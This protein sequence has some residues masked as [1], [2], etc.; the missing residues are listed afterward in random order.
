MRQSERVLLKVPIEVK[1]GGEKFFREK[2]FTLTISRYGAQIGLRHPLQSDDR[3]T[4]TNLRNN[5]SCPFRVVARVGKPL[6]EVP[7]WGVECLEPEV[8][9]W[10]ISFPENNRVEA[11]QESVE[12]LLECSRCHFREPVRLAIE[13]YR[14]LVIQ[15]ALARHC[16]KCAQTTQWKFGFG[17]VKAK[18]ARARRGSVENRRAKR[19]KTHF[20]ARIR[21]QDGREE[22]TEVEDVSKS[23]LRMISTLRM[24]EGERVRI[25]VGHSPGGNQREVEARVVW[26]EPLEDMDRVM[27]GLELDDNPGD[28]SLSSPKAN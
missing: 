13:E 9:I 18:R 16:R 12:S 8:D 11:V 28:K 15:M 25:T 7:E 19:L 5:V 14:V 24:K 10:G 21:L 6:G 1:G 3:I 4:V 23:G 2:T 17:E 20:P 27:Y 26:R 22:V